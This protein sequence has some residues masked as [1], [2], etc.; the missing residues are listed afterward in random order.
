MLD[1]EGRAVM[2]ST[3]DFW[4]LAYSFVRRLCADLVAIAADLGM[5][6]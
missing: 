1:S 2:Y 6:L 5:G 3:G 4:R